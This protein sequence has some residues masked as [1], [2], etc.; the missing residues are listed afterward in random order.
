MYITLTPVH[1]A[2]LF[3]LPSFYEFI[4]LIIHYLAYLPYTSL[5][6]THTHTGT[7]VRDIPLYIYRQ[8][9]APNYK[10][11][12]TRGS[13]L[14]VINAVFI[15]LVTISVAIRAYSRM[16]QTRPGIDDVMIYIAYVFTIG[17]TVIVLLANQSYGWDRH[18]W[19]VPAHA[20]Q[21]AAILAFCAKLAFVLASCFTRLSLIFLYYRL[22]QESTIKWYRWS[23]HFGL[24][25]NMAVFVSLV[26]VGVFGCM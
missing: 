4:H 6:L 18:T 24:F 11:P 21:G 22:I 1:L 23:I 2:R 7:M 17:L 8:W 9:P 12:V 20:I 19:D 15:S 5:S 13:G 10:D 3:P 14:V 25:F 16:K 26:F